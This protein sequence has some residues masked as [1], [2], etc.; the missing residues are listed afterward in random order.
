MVHYCRQCYQLY[1]G[2]PPII[3]GDAINLII[4]HDVMVLTPYLPITDDT[5]RGSIIHAWFYWLDLCV[6]WF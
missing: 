5:T 6:P 4:V 1:L 2:F 3:A